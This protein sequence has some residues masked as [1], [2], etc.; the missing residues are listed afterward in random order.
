MTDVFTK[1]KRKWIMSR[2]GGVNTKPE[3]IVR[4]FL[5]AMGHRFRLHRADLPGKPDIILPKHRK[6]IFVHGCFWHGHAKCHRSKR[7]STNEIFWNS[8]IDRT[9]RRDKRVLSDLKKIGWKVLIIWECETKKTEL[10]VRKL[11]NFI[12]EKKVR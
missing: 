4:S 3:K 1:E 8:K 7:P 12:D 10:M 9:I 6:I 5:H 2:V 11:E